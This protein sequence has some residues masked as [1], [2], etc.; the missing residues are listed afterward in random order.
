MIRIKK[1]DELHIQIITDNKAYLA[2]LKEHF[3]DYVEGFK[4]MQKYKAGGWDGRICVMAS[5]KSLPYGLLFSVMKFHKQYYNN[6]ELKIDND[7]KDFFTGEEIE[8]EQNLNIIPRPYQLDCIETAIKHKRC[9]L[10]VATAGG[11]SAIISYIIK[12]LI[13]EDRIQRALIIVPT[14]SLI[15]Q[16]YSDMVDYGFPETTIGKFYSKVKELDKQIVIATWQSLSKK[17]EIIEDFQCFICDECH[18]VKGQILRKLLSKSPAQWRF[19]L[20][21]TLPNSKLDMW[22]ITGYIGPVLKEYSSNDLAEQGYISKCNIKVMNLLYND[23]YDG[24]YDKV[25]DEIFTN[26]NRLRFIYNTLSNT[27]DNILVLVGKVEKEGEL[28]K[29]YLDKNNIKNKD[30]VFLWGDTK[31]EEREK[32]RLECEKRKNIILIATYGIMSVGINIPSLKYIMFASP[33]KS[34]I[35]ILQSIGRSLRLHDSKEHATI[36]DLADDV[37]YLSDH[38]MRRKHYY[39]LEKFNMEETTHHMTDFI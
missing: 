2:D 28:L 22:Q 14:Q 35:R 21:G 38:A 26:K 31:V 30:I 27:D 5:N 7:V 25:K 33:F 8:I 13:D 3:T 36:F 6:L 17:P 12:T 39:K 18:S 4:Y 20:T 37:I 23:E 11:K 15:L 9:L 16:F 34:K 24:E 10:R 29:K 19:G 32:W 1:L